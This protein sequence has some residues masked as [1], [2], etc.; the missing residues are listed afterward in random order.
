MALLWDLVRTKSKTGGAH[1]RALFAA[2]I[3]RLKQGEQQQ[4]PL[5]A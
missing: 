5:K 1:L 2:F 4:I 3:E